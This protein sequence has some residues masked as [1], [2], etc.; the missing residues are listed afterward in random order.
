MS[1]FL[2]VYY[3]TWSNITEDDN[4]K[5]ENKLRSYNNE[6]NSSGYWQK[7]KEGAIQLLLCLFHRL[8]FIERL[9]L[10]AELESKWSRD[11]EGMKCE[12]YQLKGCPRKLQL[13]AGFVNI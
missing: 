8:A 4:I 11:R 12:V 10:H 1:E 5:N 6:E 3:I 2:N 7:E 13:E 9:K